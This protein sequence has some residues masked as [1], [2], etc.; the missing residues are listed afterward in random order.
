MSARDQIMDVLRRAYQIEVEGHTFYTLCA[1]RSDKPVVRELFE[2][3][4]HD[5]VLHQGYLKS[6]VGKYAER[7]NAAFEIQRRPPDMSSIARKVFTDRFRQ[8]AQGASFEMGVVS[9]GMQL[10]T[11]AINHFRAAATAA[12][13]KEVADF[14]GFLAA[15]EQEHYD[16]LDALQKAVRA[17]FWDRSGFAPF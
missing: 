12:T 9:I 14:Y 17:D 6:V 11:N 10:E 4:A 5:E 8:E 16:A 2:K 7:G 3:L 15:W 1:T 13:D